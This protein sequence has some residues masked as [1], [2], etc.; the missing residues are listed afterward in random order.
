MFF[1][2]NNQRLDNWVVVNAG[3]SE[4]VSLGNAS[5]GTQYLSSGTEAAG[6]NDVTLATRFNA[7]TSLWCTAN[8][9]AT[10]THVITGHLV[11]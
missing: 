3:T 8:G 7:T 11:Q 2:T 5:G 1:N 10:L 6:P 4:T 9:T